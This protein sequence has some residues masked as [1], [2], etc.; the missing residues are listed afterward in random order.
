MPLVGLLGRTTTLLLFGIFALILPENYRPRSCHPGPDRGPDR[1]FPGVPAGRYR[2]VTW[3]MLSEIF[4]S[5][6]PRRY[7]KAQ[8]VAKGA[9]K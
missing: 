2:P 6:D 5:A 4:R 8:S 7:E 3:L 9:G 1:C